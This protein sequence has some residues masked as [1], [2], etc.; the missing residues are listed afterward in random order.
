MA[1]K[2]QAKKETKEEKNLPAAKEATE[3]M[4]MG[5]GA[6]GSEGL[7]S[8]D[9]LVSKILLMQGQSKF[10]QRGDAAIGQLVDSVTGE[11]LGGVTNSKTK[12]ITPIELIAFSSFKTL[13]TSKK[14]GDKF[15]FMKV[16]PMGPDNVNLAPEEVVDG[17][18]IRR[19][20]CLNFYVLRP[21]DIKAGNA[22]PYLLSVRR[23]S[24]K[25]G[26]QITT[27]G[28]KLKAFKQP[29][30]AKCI[31]LGVEFKENDQGAFWAFT[32]SP[33]RVSTQEELKEAHRWYTAFKT[34]SVRHD[35]SDLK[36]EPV[37]R[38]PAAAGE[39]DEGFDV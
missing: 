37:A 20:R 17:L 30:A 7:E 33:G 11:V 32:A 9:I 26:R 6:W 36:E 13:I 12:E 5:S 15:E 29:L 3:I 24:Y 39:P 23:T 25:A 35:D 1:A 4:E 22:F 28:Q 27:M 21:E 16:E 18:T 38:S 2:K 19:D 31:Q 10:V 34:Q 8:S 14:V